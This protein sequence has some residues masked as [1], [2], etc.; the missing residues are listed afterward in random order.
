V[1]IA[2]RQVQSDS[3]LTMPSAPGFSRPRLLGALDSIAV[4]RLYGRGQGVYRHSEPTDCW[5]RMTC[6]LAKKYALMPDGR[7]QIVEFLLPGDF[8][9]FG[10]DHTHQFIVEAMVARTMIARYPRD[11]IEALAAQDPATGELLREVAFELIARSQWRLLALARTSARQ[12]IGAFLL[13]MSVRLSG[14]HAGQFMLPMSRYDIADY[15]GLSVEAVSRAMT[16]L[17]DAGAIQLG[18]A[19]HVS[20]IDS[21]ALQR[22]EPMRRPVLAARVPSRQLPGSPSAGRNARRN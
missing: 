12:R 6:G 11:E 13:E 20:I 16:S 10:V 5:Y 9:G 4:L 21:D 22:A 17:K 8:F 14:G 3:R 7:Q 2:H 19:R 1:D 18:A 15:V